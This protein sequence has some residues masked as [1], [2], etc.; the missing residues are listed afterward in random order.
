MNPGPG[1]GGPVEPDS[2]V[3]VLI[4]V[5]HVK[6]MLHGVEMGCSVNVLCMVP[7]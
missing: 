4:L 7:C 6:K 1:I 3:G 2:D 5:V